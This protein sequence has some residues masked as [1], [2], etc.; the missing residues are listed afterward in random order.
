MFH[1]KNSFHKR[2]FV[3]S[4]IPDK[5]EAA[6][7][8]DGKLLANVENVKAEAVEKTVHITAYGKGGCVSILKGTVN[9]IGA[10][11]KYILCNGPCRGKKQS[12]SKRSKNGTL[13]RT[14]G[15]RH[16]CA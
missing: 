8:Y 7:K 12:S 15:R 11:I 4:T 14:S 13:C 9:A 6:V 5:A 2:C 16:Y 3:S 10:L 1:L